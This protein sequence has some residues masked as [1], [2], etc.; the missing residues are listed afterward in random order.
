MTYLACLE[1]NWILQ[2]KILK[3]KLRTMSIY[4]S[5]AEIEKW[6]KVCR[7]PPSCC[8][9]ML[10]LIRWY[11]TDTWRL[12]HFKTVWWFCWPIDGRNF[13]S[14]KQK[15]SQCLRQSSFFFISGLFRS[16]KLQS[17]WCIICHHGYCL[18]STAL[19]CFPDKV[20]WSVSIVWLTQSFCYQ[21]VNGT[22]PTVFHWHNSLKPH[23]PS[24]VRVIPAE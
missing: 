5:D 2:K 16:F 23:T 17:T 8:S 7:L 13:E 3:D 9:A 12:C 20:N 19:F 10:L 6:P 18:C 11:S 4:R 1:K 22:H 15:T 24:C 14:T 21:L